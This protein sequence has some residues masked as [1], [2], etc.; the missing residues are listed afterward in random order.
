VRRCT[1]VERGKLAVDSVQRSHGVPVVVFVVTDHHLFRDSA[2]SRRADGDRA[3]SWGMAGSFL[4]EWNCSLC[5][6]KMIQYETNVHG[7][8][9][10]SAVRQTAA[11][12]VRQE[13]FKRSAW[14]VVCFESLP[15][16]EIRRSPRRQASAACLTLQV[17]R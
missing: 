11:G 8:N 14:G 12:L 7:V 13:P 2:K 3:I 16:P 10:D 6:N 5:C 4:R 17:Y 9:Q 15:R 1:R